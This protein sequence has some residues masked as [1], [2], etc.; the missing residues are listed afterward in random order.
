MLYSE[1]V[2]YYCDILSNKKVYGLACIVIIGIYI[3]QDI[4]KEVY[5]KEL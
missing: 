2:V 3:V 1:C 5:I 4:I